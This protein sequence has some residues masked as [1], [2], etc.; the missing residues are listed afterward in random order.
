M[1]H[2]TECISL[3]RDDIAVTDD[4]FAA[5]I[6]DAH[7]RDREAFLRDQL[8]ADAEPFAAFG[9]TPKGV[10]NLRD[11]ASFPNPTDLMTPEQAARYLLIQFEDIQKTLDLLAAAD[12]GLIELDRQQD[13]TIAA[14][15][16]RLEHL[17]QRMDLRAEETQALSKRLENV[18]QLATGN[19]RLRPV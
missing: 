9:F 7:D 11:V 10:H 2:L 6:L 16:E 5:F 14:L 19:A 18:T 8:N 3:Y 1:S 15:G 12:G 17:E 13:I 4:Q